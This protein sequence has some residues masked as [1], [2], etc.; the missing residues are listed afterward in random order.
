MKSSLKLMKLETLTKKW[1]WSGSLISV[2]RNQINSFACYEGKV[3]NKKIHTICV[4]ANE[5]HLFCKSFTLIKINFSSIPSSISLITLIFRLL[6]SHSRALQ[7]LS[8][9][10]LSLS[11][12]LLLCVNRIGKAGCVRVKKKI[13]FIFFSRIKDCWI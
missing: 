13:L 2:F 5:F 1:A 10:M 3:F 12:L 9:M 7:L 6:R 8:P 11:L 4:C